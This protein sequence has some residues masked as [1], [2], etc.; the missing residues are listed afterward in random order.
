MGPLEIDRP[1]RA[2]AVDLHATAGE[3]IGHGDIFGY[4]QGIPERQH[5]HRRAD[6]YA[7]GDL[8]DLDRHHQRVG[9]A[10]FPAGWPGSGACGC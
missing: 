1:K 5:Q 7:S 2:N 3:L 8:P 9:R 10:S 4:A 6:A